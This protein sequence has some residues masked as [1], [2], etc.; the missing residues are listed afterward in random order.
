MLYEVRAFNNRNAI[1]EIK[2]EKKQKSNKQKHQV[3][4]VEM[5]LQVD[6]LKTKKKRSVDFVSFIKSE[7]R[8][9]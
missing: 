1:N 5:K 9:K 8:K 3:K 2:R 6:K 4:I 7:R